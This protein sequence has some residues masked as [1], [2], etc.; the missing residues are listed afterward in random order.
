MEV[1]LITFRTID[2]AR[3]RAPGK[4]LSRASIP[5]AVAAT[6]K[7]R[8]QQILV[9]R[10]RHVLDRVQGDP[11]V[12]RVPGAVRRVQ[13]ILG[14]L[15]GNAAFENGAPCHTVAKTGISLPQNEG[16]VAEVQN[17]PREFVQDIVPDVAVQVVLRRNWYDGLKQHVD[18]VQHRDLVAERQA[19]SG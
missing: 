12:Q 19:Y 11:C 6:R 13:G 1:H 14:L 4:A 9:I 7:R 15:E 2:Q 17:V 18:R 16:H 10:H 3:A 5:S 8:V